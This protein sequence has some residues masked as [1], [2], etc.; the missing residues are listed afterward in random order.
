MQETASETLRAP[1]D[2]FSCPNLPSGGKNPLGDA[3][4]FDVPFY[5]LFVNSSQMFFPL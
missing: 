3:L 2:P 1:L 5:L 4:L